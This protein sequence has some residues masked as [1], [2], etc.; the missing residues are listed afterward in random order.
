MAIYTSR[1]EA[2]GRSNTAEHLVL[3]FQPPELREIHFC[4]LNSSG[5]WSFVMMSGCP[6]QMDIGRLLIWLLGEDTPTGVR[7][8]Q[9]LEHG[10]CPSP[11]LGC[12]ETK[13]AVDGPVLT[14]LGVSRGG[15]MT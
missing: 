6:E 14:K 9:W 11:G 10:V 15:Q 2:S 7:S 13:P 5:L 1:R 12:F 3:N 8:A 4:G